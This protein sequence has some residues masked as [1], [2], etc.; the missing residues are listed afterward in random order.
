MIRCTFKNISLTAL[1]CAMT[2]SLTPLQAQKAEKVVRKKIYSV[3]PVYPDLLKRSNI[4]GVV[5]LLVVISPKGSVETVNQLGGNAAL[6]E[7]AVNAVKKWKYVP[8]DTETT[9]EISIAFDPHSYR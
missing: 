8:A 3:E 7:S 5:R 9:Q 4:G 6:V 2:L 1:L